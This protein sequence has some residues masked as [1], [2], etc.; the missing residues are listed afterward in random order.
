MTYDQYDHLTLYFH[1]N[2]FGKHNFRTINYWDI[3]YSKKRLNNCKKLWS[4]TKRKGKKKKQQCKINQKYIIKFSNRVK[5]KKLSWS[6]LV[7]VCKLY[8]TICIS[9]SRKVVATNTVVRQKRWGFISPTEA[10]KQR[11]QYLSNCF[12]V[13]VVQLLTSLPIYIY[14]WLSRG[15]LSSACSGDRGLF[16]QGWK[17]L[18]RVSSKDSG[19]DQPQVYAFLDSWLL[20]SRVEKAETCGL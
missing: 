20:L 7:I 1:I 11:S 6:V 2:Y 3:L 8:F 9:H 5:V 19:G 4:S 13:S 10:I 12:E 17:S 16:C 15:F 18:E 14:H